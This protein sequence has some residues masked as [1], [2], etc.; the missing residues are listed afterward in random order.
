MQEFWFLHFLE[1][2]AS[3][4]TLIT[5]R[6]RKW[7][8][9]E[10]FPLWHLILSLSHAARLKAA[11]RKGS[12]RWCKQKFHRPPEYYHVSCFARLHK[13]VLQTVLVACRW[14]GSRRYSPTKE[15]MT[16]TEF[17]Y[18]HK[19]AEDY[20]RYVLQIQQPGSK[21]NKTSGCYKTW[22]PLSR[23]KWKGLWSSAWISLMVSVDTAEQYSTKWW[24]RNL[25]WHC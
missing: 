10:T 24:K 1:F 16:D 4:T 11:R 12:F 21:P 8:A 20:L 7:P 15:K 13:L 2:K 6:M 5:Y 14:A 19:L 23:T 22:L 3:K 25:R 17:D 9:L 18:V